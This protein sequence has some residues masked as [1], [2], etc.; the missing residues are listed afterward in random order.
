[1]KITKVDEHILINGECLEVMDKLIQ[2]GVKVDAIITD[3]PYGT[4]RCKWDSIIPLD[5]MWKRLKSVRKD[6]GCIAL[7]NAEPFGSM[8]RAS[9]IREYKYD[10][11]W[12][13]NLKTNNLNAKI[14][15]MGGH[16]N[17][18]VFAKKKITYNPQK[19]KRTTEV[20]S[21][22]K[23][24]SKTEVYGKQK[25]NYVDNQSDWINPDTVIKDIKCVHSSSGR[26]H[27]NQKPLE[28]MEYLVK[29]YTNEGDTVLDFT[30]GS[31]TTGVACQN[32]GRNFIGIE[33]DEKYFDIGVGRMVEN[34]K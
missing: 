1:M 2:D 34:T 9:N 28:L 19:R 11:V 27:P 5:E 22:N 17:I 24:N 32:T 21:G 16:E 33:L 18:S 7:F 8:L 30:A 20:K 26:V 12:V 14:M 23:K 31:F 3:P 6:N 25:E 15:P 13:K 10:W 29:T 4:T